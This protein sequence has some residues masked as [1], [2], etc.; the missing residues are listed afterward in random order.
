M[1]GTGVHTS[2]AGVQGSTPSTRVHGSTR[3]IGMGSQG[4]R[5]S[6]PPKGTARVQGVHTSQGYRVSTPPR[7][8]RC[9]HLPGIQGVHT[10]QWYRVPTP[11]RGTGC[12]YHSLITNIRV[13]CVVLKLYTDSQKGSCH[14]GTIYCKSWPFMKC[15]FD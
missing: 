15:F 7:G 14:H 9:P 6:T 4:Y 10:S 11:P 12:S 8:T 2:H 5:V 3:P 13:M 1:R